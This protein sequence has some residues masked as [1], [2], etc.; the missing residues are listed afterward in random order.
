MQGGQVTIMPKPGTD[1]VNLQEKLQTLINTNRISL[2][3]VKIG[4]LYS[5][6]AFAKY[7]EMKKTKDASGKDIIDPKAS[8][9]DFMMYLTD[10]QK[11][12]NKSGDLQSILGSQAMLT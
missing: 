8:S 9:Q 7:A 4:M 10:L 6:P 2:D 1:V 5:S 11:A 12:G 3:T